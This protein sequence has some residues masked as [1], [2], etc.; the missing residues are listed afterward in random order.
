MNLFAK[1]ILFNLTILPLFESVAYA[2]DCLDEADR[3][4]KITSI[5]YLEDSDT[6]I[7]LHFAPKGCEFP[8]GNVL[9]C[10]YISACQKG[11]SYNQKG[12]HVYRKDLDLES[13]CT[14]AKEYTVNG[15]KTL[16]S[17]SGASSNRK[18]KAYFLC[19]YKDFK[20]ILLVI[21]DKQ[22]K[23]KLPF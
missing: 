15:K 21:G 1:L 11:K 3:K 16:S 19:P 7:E 13:F 20:S 14:S 17:M 22:K 5:C 10:A 23:C 4:R 8:E 18:A 9:D 6:R 2:L 12:R